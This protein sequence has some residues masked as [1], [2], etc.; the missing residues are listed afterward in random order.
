M[1][2]KEGRVRTWVNHSVDCQHPTVL[3]VFPSP[4]WGMYGRQQ[5]EAKSVCGSDFPWVASTSCMW[6]SLGH[7]TTGRRDPATWDPASLGHDWYAAGHEC[8]RKE[9]PA[10]RPCSVKCLLSSRHPLEEAWDG[11]VVLGEPPSPLSKLGF[12]TQLLQSWWLG[13][14]GLAPPWHEEEF[15]GMSVP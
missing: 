15:N 11:R 4:C 6:A 7:S 13:A 1:E 9:T 10:P 14:L 8:A 12:L 5:G 3:R 2:A